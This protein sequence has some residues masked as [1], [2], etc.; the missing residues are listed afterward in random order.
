MGGVPFKPPVINRSLNAEVN[1]KGKKGR[2]LWFQEQWTVFW[3][4]S[5]PQNHV[6][7]C[8]YT[9]R[10]LR[11]LHASVPLPSVAPGF[12][13]F[14]A[15]TNDTHL[16]P[17]KLQKTLSTSLLELGW[18]RGKF[19][20]I[21]ENILEE[22]KHNFLQVLH[23]PQPAN[24]QSQLRLRFISQPPARFGSRDSRTVVGT[25]RTAG[26]QS[27]DL[28]FHPWIVMWPR[29]AFTL[30]ETWDYLWKVNTQ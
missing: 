30:L 28:S 6:K 23:S 13:T 2:G 20:S 29:D 22:T 16:L 8:W 10:P 14:P 12:H 15:D 1:Q 4:Y 18:G 19:Q 5:I 3:G 7:Q 27:A 26:L 24:R 9:L 21:S 25:V 11:F 17:V